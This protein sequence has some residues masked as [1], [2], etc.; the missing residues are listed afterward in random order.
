MLSPL[1]SHDLLPLV[2]CISNSCV[3]L[4]KAFF[5]QLIK[6]VTNLLCTTPSEFNFCPI[7]YNILIFHFVWIFLICVVLYCIPS[8]SHDDHIAG[9]GGTVN[10]Q[11]KKK[12]KP[13][14]LLPSISFVKLSVSYQMLLYPHTLL[15]SSFRTMINVYFI[16]L[17]TIIITL[18][19][20]FTASLP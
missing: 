14:R 4:R 8:S 6:N 15:Q 20:I 18:F 11:N 12:I 16:T 2:I 9:G 1:P 13:C 5:D 10:K 3:L 7:T 19:Y 17:I